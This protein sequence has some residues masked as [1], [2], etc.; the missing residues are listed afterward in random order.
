[1]PAIE[2]LLAPGSTGLPDCKCGAE[3]RL[4]AVKPCGDTEV[5]IFKCDACDH[6]FQLMVWA[7][8]APASHDDDRTRCSL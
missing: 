7:A 2:N 6:E 5:R 4:F 1:M 3:L 8:P